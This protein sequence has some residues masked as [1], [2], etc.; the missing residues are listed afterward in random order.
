M[1]VI[2][3]PVDKTGNEGKVKEVVKRD[4]MDMF[5]VMKKPKVSRTGVYIALNSG[6]AFL[7]GGSR[8]GTTGAVAHV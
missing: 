6:R 7:E 3:V 2:D 8:P 1:N 5:N 4:R